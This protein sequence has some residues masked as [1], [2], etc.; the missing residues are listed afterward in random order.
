M[1]AI[2]GLFQ[3]S[4]FIGDYMDDNVYFNTP[5]A[6]LPKLSDAWYLDRYRRSNIIV[7][8]GQGAWEEAMLADACAIKKVLDGKD[9]PSWVDIW[10]HDVNH[11]WPWWRKMIPY[12]F[13]QLDKR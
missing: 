4:M 6:Y 7:C 10:G 2:S 5:L 12:Y 11:D 8:V 1:L 9:V 3:L 13:D